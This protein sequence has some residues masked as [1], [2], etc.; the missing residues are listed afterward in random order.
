MIAICNTDYVKHLNR[1]V[2]SIEAYDFEDAMET[3][4]GLARELGIEIPH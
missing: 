1:M 2:N 4:K 3:L